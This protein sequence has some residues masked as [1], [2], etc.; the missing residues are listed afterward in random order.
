[1]FIADGVR[2]TGRGEAYYGGVRLTGR[3][4]AYYGGVMLTGRGRLIVEGV[5]LTGHGEKLPGWVDSYCGRGETYWTGRGLL[6][7]GEAY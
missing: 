3:G 4:E 2:P 5:R 6:R 1:M 7:W